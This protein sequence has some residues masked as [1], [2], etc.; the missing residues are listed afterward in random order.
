MGINELVNQL[1]EARL[2][3]QSAKEYRL[4]LEAQLAEKLRTCADGPIPLGGVWK[5]GEF[6]WLSSG[7]PIKE[8]LPRAG[9]LA[10]PSPSLYVPALNDGAFCRIQLAD[11]VLVEFPE[12]GSG[13]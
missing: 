11:Q 6:C 12:A 5:L 10:D 9:R 1:Y 13:E 4:G 7:R 8:T 2:A 3:E